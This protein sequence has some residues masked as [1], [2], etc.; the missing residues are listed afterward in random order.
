MEQ[1]IEGGHIVS[2]LL[3]SEDYRDKLKDLN[4]TQ[5]KNINRANALTVRVKAN[6]RIPDRH[7]QKTLSLSEIIQQIKPLSETICR[8][9]SD[10]MTLVVIPWSNL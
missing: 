9:V 7:I 10:L 4:E 5:Q 2:S 8:D 3:L 1:F 6:L